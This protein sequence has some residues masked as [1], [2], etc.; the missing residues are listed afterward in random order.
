M[1]ANLRPQTAGT[2]RSDCC[3]DADHPA[4]QFQELLELLGDEYACA[5]LCALDDSPAT[6]GEL[7]DRCEMS[8]PTVYRR[9]SALTDAGIVDSQACDGKQGKTYH[10]VVDCFEF[11]LQSDGVNGTAGPAAVN[12]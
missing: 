6:A 2:D 8:R 3:D 9:L 7:V 11:R 4:V 12:R 5:L 10:L 1:T